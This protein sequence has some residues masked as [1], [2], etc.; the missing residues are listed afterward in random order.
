V[1]KLQTEFSVIDTNKDGKIDSEEL[2]IFLKKNSEKRLNRETTLGELE[3]IEKWIVAPIFE[4][5]DIDG[6]GYVSI[7]EYITTF[8]QHKK[9]LEES[10]IVNQLEI[11][12]A[13]S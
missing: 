4:S 2:L 9:N 3:D 5:L 10:M 6:D 7:Q 8:L 13:E 12:D 11:L 1:R